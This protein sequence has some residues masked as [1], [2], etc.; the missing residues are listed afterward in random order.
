MS[1][2]ESLSCDYLKKAKYWHIAVPS[3]G[4]ICA[5]VGLT[6]FDGA[7]TSFNF[8]SICNFYLAYF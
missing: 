7:Q 8:Y 3:N 1:V 4:I 6:L 5:V 2:V